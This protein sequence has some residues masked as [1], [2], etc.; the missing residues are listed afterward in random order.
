MDALKGQNILAHGIAMGAF[1]GHCCGVS[2]Y[3]TK[4]NPIIGTHGDAMG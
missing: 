2:M 1:V 3:F 4:H